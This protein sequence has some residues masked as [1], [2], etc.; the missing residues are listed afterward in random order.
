MLTKRNSYSVTCPPKS[1][2]AAKA[3][4]LDRI[5]MTNADIQRVLFLAQIFAFKNTCIKTGETAERK[6][7]IKAVIAHSFPDGLCESQN[8]K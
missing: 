1:R 8:G 4:E 5:E 2:E 3:A 7:G 6:Y